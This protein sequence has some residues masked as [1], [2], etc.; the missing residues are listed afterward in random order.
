MV[1]VE[2]RFDLAH[3]PGTS[4]TVSSRY[5]VV[6]MQWLPITSPRLLNRSHEV[7]CLVSRR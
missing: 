4:L 3:C 1:A 6:L 5:H 2:T 7:A